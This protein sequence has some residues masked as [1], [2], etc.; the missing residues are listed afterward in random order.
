VAG[1]GAVTLRL[2]AVAAG[3]HPLY[4]LRGQILDGGVA[5]TAVRRVRAHKRSNGAVIG[6]AD[7]VAGVFD[8]AVGYTFDEYYLVPIDLDSAAIDW[9]PPV[10]NRVLSILVTD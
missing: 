2:T 8:I 4:R 1:Q 3:L 9:A 7:T 10:A 6:E 5:V